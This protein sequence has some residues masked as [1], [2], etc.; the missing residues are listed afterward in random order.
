MKL[1]LSILDL[2][3]LYNGALVHDFIVTLLWA[4][5]KQL[6]FLPFPLNGRL[7]GKKDHV[8]SLLLPPVLRI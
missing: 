2:L 3:S 4:L 6:V 7:C 8:F 5:L 1:M